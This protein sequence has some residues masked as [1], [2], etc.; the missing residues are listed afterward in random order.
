MPMHANLFIII[1]FVME[2]REIRIPQPN[3]SFF[4]TTIEARKNSASLLFSYNPVSFKFPCQCS[5]CIYQTSERLFS[6]NFLKKPP[7]TSKVNSKG[8]T[9]LLEKL[10]EISQKASVRLNLPD[11]TVFKAGKAVFTMQQSRDRSL[12]W[13]TSPDKLKTSE[14]IKVISNTTKLKKREE[15]SG[16][17]NKIVLSGCSIDSSKEVACLRYMQK[18]VLNDID[19]VFAENEE[20]AIRIMTENDFIGLLS[21]RPSS[22]FWKQ[23]AY[24]QCLLKCR[25]SIGESFIFDYTLHD[26]KYD[27]NLAKEYEDSDVLE[28]QFLVQGKEAYA[29]FI[30]D[31]IQFLFAKYLNISLKSIQGEFIQDENGRIWLIHATNI[32]TQP[33]TS[34][35]EPKNCE[36]IPQIIRKTIN[37]DL[38][39]HI[40]LVS[41][42]P[43]N[44]R[45]LKLS[46]FMKQECDKI[47]AASRIKKE[48]KEAFDIETIA[49]YHK[50]RPFTPIDSNWHM[51]NIS[52]V[53]LVRSKS[54]N[55][56]SKGT[57][58]KIEVSASFDKK[59]FTP[60]KSQ[61]SWIYIPKIP[62]SQL[63]GSNLASKLSLTPSLSPKKN[64]SISPI[65]DISIWSSKKWLIT[66]VKEGYIWPSKNSS[67]S[68]INQRAFSPLKKHR[69]KTNSSLQL[70]LPLKALIKEIQPIIQ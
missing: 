63:K 43:K 40:A 34:S 1:K 27:S 9:Y 57:S 5:I 46:R 65:K 56:R 15:V 25:H 68:P 33:I 59:S 8:F 16:I 39:N 69:N 55:K 11:T 42:V 44:N 13:I 36:I 20:G 28:N 66:P 38:I 50:L 31:K 41:N 30:F 70:K 32:K 61:N 18:D 24:I 52:R 21:K 17:T 58:N 37:E 47:F 54:A 35:V 3:N 29:A 62:V 49:A 26:A 12:N 7:A 14:I 48:G 23:L 64:F 67:I 6:E 2:D 53:K 51:H 22:I 45:T 60:V 19:E 10:G 4:L